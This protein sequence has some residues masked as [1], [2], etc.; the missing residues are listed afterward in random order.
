MPSRRISLTAARFD[1]ASIIR[2]LA[3]CVAAVTAYLL[4]KD[5][6]VGDGVLWIL[7]IAVLLNVG[8]KVLSGRPGWAIFAR[9]FSTFCGLISWSA[10]VRMTGRLCTL[11]L[12]ESPSKYLEFRRIA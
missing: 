1:I 9:A 11:V 12:N 6:H 10:L 2:H 5:L 4:R 3:I 7:G 8:T